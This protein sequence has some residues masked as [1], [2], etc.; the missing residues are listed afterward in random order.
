MGP[1][2]GILSKI[3]GV[4]KQLEGVDIDDRQIDWVQAIILSMTPEERS[5]PHIMNVKKAQNCGRFGQ[6][7]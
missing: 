7:H 5:H 4:G 6:K 3:P 1:L 2:K